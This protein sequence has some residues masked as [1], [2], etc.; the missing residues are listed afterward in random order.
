M[1][2]VP[3]GI[4][5]APEQPKPEVHPAVAAKE[6]RAAKL[7]N[8]SAGLAKL[9][10]EE[11]SR[12][13][14]QAPKVEKL[15]SEIGHEPPAEKPKLEQVEAKAD[16]AEPKVEE[17]K[18]EEKLKADEKP[19]EP[20]PQTAK[21]LAAI[22]KQAKKFRDEQAAAKREFDQERA[23]YRAEMAREQAEWKS[24]LEDYKAAR[25][26]AKRDPIGFLR[27]LGIETED[28]WERVGRGAF[29]HTK[30]GKAD[31]RAIE[32]AARHDRDAAH[33]SEIAELR[34]TV[35]DL[36]DEIKTYKSSVEARSYVETWQADAVK[37]IPKDKPTLI[38][39][40]H[41]KSPAKAQKALLAIGAELERANDGE[42]PSHA[43]VIAEFEKRERAELEDRG[44]DVDALL[45]P[46]AAAAPAPAKQAPK[47][48][49]P[50]MPANGTRP[51]NGYPTR[52]QRLAAV[53]A[54]LKKL[55]AEA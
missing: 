18:A 36:T 32:V 41:E 52:E 3:V 14:P 17:P 39:R 24:Q 50:A 47:T 54:G 21:A 55:T 2:E 26:T 8:V 53:T 42:T 28:D 16:E 43:D 33:D 40:L 35:S 44:V 38:A 48:L 37:A 51:I 10:T 9:K 13:P 49:D 15:P 5:P 20:D 29:P 12:E 11:P 27:K 19:E 34:R 46:A 1:A 4:V 30:Q 6:A 45:K 7:K 23:S 22:D 31:P 25:A